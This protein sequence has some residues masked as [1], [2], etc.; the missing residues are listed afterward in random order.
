MNKIKNK[1]KSKYIPFIPN[2]LLLLNFIYKVK[3]SLFFKI[4]TVLTVKLKF[5]FK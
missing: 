2:Y 5:N 1:N 3:N 4:T